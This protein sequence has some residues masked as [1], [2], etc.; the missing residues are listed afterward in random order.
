MWHFLVSFWFIFLYRSNRVFDLAYLG[1]CLDGRFATP[2]SLVFLDGF[3]ES[4][5]SLLDINLEIQ[6]VILR[7]EGFELVPHLFLLLEGLHKLGN[8]DGVLPHLEVLVY[9]V[10]NQT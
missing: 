10:L 3:L 9:L 2:V 1:P 6:F 8:I 5:S 4:N 7:E